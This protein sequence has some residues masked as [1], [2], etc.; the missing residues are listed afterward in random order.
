MPD[1][2]LTRQGSVLGN[3]TVTYPTT[4]SIEERRNGQVAVLAPPAGKG[5]LRLIAMADE[6]PPAAL[7]RVYAEAVCTR[8]LRSIGLQANV[9][10]IRRISPDQMTV[11]SAGVAA[12]TSIV[13]IVHVFRTGQVVAAFFRAPS[14]DAH[15]STATRIMKSLRMKPSP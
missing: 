2:T 14:T 10:A 6:Q 7:T 13:E 5:R 4:W 12:G 8:A 11:L 9:R 3:F 15:F 1:V